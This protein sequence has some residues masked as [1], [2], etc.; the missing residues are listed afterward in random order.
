MTHT[1]SQGLPRRSLQRRGNSHFG[2]LSATS[3]LNL[4]AAEASLTVWHNR[5]TSER[6]QQSLQ[7]SLTGE[8][9]PADNTVENP[10][11]NPS[12]SAEGSQGGIRQI[13]AASP[14]ARR[15]SPT[16]VEARQAHRR[17]PFSK[18]AKRP[19]PFSR[20]TKLKGFRTTAGARKGKGSRGRE[21]LEEALSPKAKEAE[22][23]RPMPP[24]WGQNRG[25]GVIPPAF[26]PE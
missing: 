12:E 15:T 20:H 7:H 11:A 6:N 23:R 8:D 2:S 1:R 14:S 5:T 24:T 22:N 4:V 10:Q 17:L 26:W 19:Q 21:S 13:R 16:S 18:E 25:E 9:K 3:R